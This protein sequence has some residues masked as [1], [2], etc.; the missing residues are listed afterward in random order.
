MSH[1]VRVEFEFSADVQISGGVGF[2][3]DHA[4]RPVVPHSKFNAID[5]LTDGGGVYAFEMWERDS[6]GDEEDDRRVA[7]YVGEAGNLADRVKQYIAASD[8]VKVAQTVDDPVGAKTAAYV[9]ANMVLWVRSGWPR[10]NEQF[11]HDVTFRR[12]VSATEAG[13]ALNLDRKDDRLLI[14]ASALH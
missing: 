10:N 2:D 9:A 1:S 4:S 11:R 7:V 6:D 14:E 5:G 12:V 3:P 8:P 13:Q